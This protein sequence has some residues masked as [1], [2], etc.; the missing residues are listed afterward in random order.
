MKK[1]ID[2]LIEKIIP[3]VKPDQFKVVSEIV[4]ISKVIKFY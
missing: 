1:K 4:K 3:V 2:E